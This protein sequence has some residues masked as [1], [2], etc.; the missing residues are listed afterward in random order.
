VQVAL[1]LL[2]HRLGHVGVLQLRRREELGPV[3]EIAPERTVGAVGHDAVADTHRAG[4]DGVGLVGS[5]VVCVV[6]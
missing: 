1:D 4:C 5:D 3:R 2:P 6:G